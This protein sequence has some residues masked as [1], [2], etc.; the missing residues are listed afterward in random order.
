MKHF[1]RFF[2][3]VA[4]FFIVTPLFAAYGGEPATF[5]SSTTNPPGCSNKAPIRVWPFWAKAVGT[6]AI[7]LSWGAMGDT[8]SWTVAYGVASRTYIYGVSNFGNGDSRSFRIGSLPAGTYYVTI[9]ANNG[10]MPGPFADE[11]KVVVGGG[12]AFIGGQPSNLT[13]QAAPLEVTA[14]PVEGN[15]YSAQTEGTNR[16]KP[17]SVQPPVIP[18]S[19]VRPSFLQGILN[20]FSG[21]FGR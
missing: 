18:P 13:V 14:S 6:N 9:R 20:F 5:A 15:Q 17:P 1:T 2:L 21:L 12:S 19:Q 8:S 11:W 7:N 3:I 16:V 10:C 4:S